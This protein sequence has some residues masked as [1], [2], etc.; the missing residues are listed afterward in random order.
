MRGLDI[1]K[2]SP[3]SVTKLTLSLRV[4]FIS[5]QLTANKLF[6]VNPRAI[7]GPPKMSLLLEAKSMPALIIKPNQMHTDDLGWNITS[8][9]QGQ[10]LV[11]NLNRIVSKPNVT[12]GQILNCTTDCIPVDLMFEENFPTNTQVWNCLDHRNDCRQSGGSV[13][14]IG[15]TT[16]TRTRS[17][18]SVI[19][20][21]SVPPRA[22][23]GPTT[24]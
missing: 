20:R 16:A 7:T 18:T 8:N 4:C 15:A 6:P 12:P 11:Q 1:H 19:W 3:V 5:S 24:N 13:L 17:V 14:P 2:N 22:W 23:V 21:S 10:M 9:Q